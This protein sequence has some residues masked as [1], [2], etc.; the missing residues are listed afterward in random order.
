V[1]R[2]VKAIDFE[3]WDKKE[4]IKIDDINDLSEDIQEIQKNTWQ[5]ILIE[6]L[7]KIEPSAFERI[8]RRFLRELGF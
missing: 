3:R 7:Q 2:K 8:C 5:E 4:K 1:K 6:E